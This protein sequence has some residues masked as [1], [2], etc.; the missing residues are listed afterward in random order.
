MIVAMKTV[1]RACDLL[2]TMRPM[3][4]LHGYC[5]TGGYSAQMSTA[6]SSSGTDATIY[7]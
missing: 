5:Q 1:M 2:T 7:R 6:D 4:K 3:M